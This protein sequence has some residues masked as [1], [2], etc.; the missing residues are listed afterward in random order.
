MENN[1]IY[2]DR[3]ER[4]E[5]WDFKGVDTK[6]YSHGMHPYPAMMIP[7]VARSLIE[8]F[9]ENSKT[10]LDPFMGSGSTIIEGIVNPNI[11]EIYAIELNPLGILIAKTKSEYDID[12]S[13]LE[14]K[15]KKLK[16]NFNNI[17]AKDI[18]FK[19]ID[20]WFENYVIKDLSKLRKY[21]FAIEDEKVRN[22]F[23]TTFSETVRKVSNQKKGEFKLVKMKPDKLDK[24]NPDVLKTFC[25]IFDKNINCIN[26]LKEKG[27]NTNI[28]IYTN[29]TRRGSEI[30]SNS[31]DLLITSPPYGDSGT[32]VAYGQFSRL[33]SQWIGYDYE[34][35]KSVDKEGL[36]GRP[37]K[38]LENDIESPTLQS[39]LE[40]ISQYDHKRARQVLAFYQDFEYC[41][42]DMDRVMKKNSKLCFVVGNRNVKG[43]R[44]NTDE[45]LS[46]MFVNKGNYK[47]IKTIIR[48]IPN[49]TMPSKNSPSNEKGN[50]TSTMNNE[51]IV[52]LEKIE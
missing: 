36:G 12:I 32:T 14:N 40:E 41:I 20:I 18:D 5:Q 15:I 33:N 30:P 11:E 24:H 26:K 25:E 42:Q 13:K 10:L 46:E 45:I 17:T 34:T 39:S 23:L 51:Y 35:I 49:K 48:E 28:N 19:N 3:R 47:H 37:A 44:L 27:K 29:D 6:E 21:I 50:T 9:G 1:N 43:V 22:F 38:T 2:K 8:N 16:N 7:Q 52:V 31:V 4:A